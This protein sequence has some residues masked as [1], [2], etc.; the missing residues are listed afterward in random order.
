MFIILSTTLQKSKIDYK[1]IWTTA[2]FITD[3]EK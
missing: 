1:I 2:E 3:K